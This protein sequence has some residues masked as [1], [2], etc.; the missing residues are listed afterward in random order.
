MSADGRRPLD[1]LFN[2]DRDNVELRF[3]GR[4]AE[5]LVD[6]E[7]KVKIAWSGCVPIEMALTALEEG[8]IL[9]WFAAERAD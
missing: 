8:M 2:I 7:S 6:G 1:R 9:Q 5:L 4:D 3:T